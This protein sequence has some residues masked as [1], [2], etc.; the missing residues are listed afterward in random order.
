MEL[1]D[2]RDAQHGLALQVIDV[3]EEMKQQDAKTDAITFLGVLSLCCHAGLVKEGRLC[4]DSMV[5][6]GVEPELDHYSC[7]VDLLGRVGL[8]EEAR[9]VM[10]K[11]PIALFPPT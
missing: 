2:S 11:M 4:F 7:V 8:L 10:S 1:N 6:R 9:D 5:E 3:F